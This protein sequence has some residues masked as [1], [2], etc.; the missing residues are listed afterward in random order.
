MHISSLYSRSRHYVPWRSNLQHGAVSEGFFFQL[1]YIEVLIVLVDVSEKKF[2]NRNKMFIGNFG[3][4]FKEEQLKDLCKVPATLAAW[5]FP[6]PYFFD[7]T[8]TQVVYVFMFNVDMVISM[9]FSH[10]MF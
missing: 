2:S 6:V 8:L 1:V 3:P 5:S 10:V 9:M 7:Y 4:N